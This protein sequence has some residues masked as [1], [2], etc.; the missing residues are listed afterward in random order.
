MNNKLIDMQPHLYAK[1]RK[2][3]SLCC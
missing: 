3:K 1:D 2:A